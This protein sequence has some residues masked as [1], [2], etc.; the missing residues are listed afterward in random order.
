VEQGGD[1]VALEMRIGAL[2]S[3]LIL[4]ST[5]GVSELAGERWP[6][7]AEFGAA[8]RRLRKP[9]YILPPTAAA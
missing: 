4:I 9:L 3:C 6:D 7:V 8:V 1:L 2:V 5:P